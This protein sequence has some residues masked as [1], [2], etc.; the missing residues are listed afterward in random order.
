VV[1]EGEGKT[2]ICPSCLAQNPAGATKCEKCGFPFIGKPFEGPSALE[3]GETFTY[4]G[5]RPFKGRIQAVALGFPQS[6][7]L[8]LRLFCG[9]TKEVCDRCILHASNLRLVFENVKKAGRA[10]TR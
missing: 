9:G 3:V 1:S 4:T 10:L 8:N 6:R 2:S 7:Y 5:D